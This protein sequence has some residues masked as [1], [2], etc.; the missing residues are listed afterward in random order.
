MIGHHISLRNVHAA[1]T[2]GCHWTQILIG[3]IY[4][5]KIDARSNLLTLRYDI[6]SYGSTG[7]SIS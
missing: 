1:S 4:D 7:G 6:I 5:F 2:S 3:W